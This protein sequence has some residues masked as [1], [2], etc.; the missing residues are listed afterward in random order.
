MELIKIVETKKIV[1][2]PNGIE[3][4]TLCNVVHEAGRCTGTGPG[5]TNCNVCV[6]SRVNWDDFV[7][8]VNK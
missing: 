5:Y 2:I 4:N 6:F 8:E 7:K 1:K 3:R